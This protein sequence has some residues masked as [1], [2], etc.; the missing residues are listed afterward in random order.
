VSTTDSTAASPVGLLGAAQRNLWRRDGYLHL[1]SALTREHVDRLLRGVDEAVSAFRRLPDDQQTAHMGATGSM[2][3]DDMRLRNVVSLSGFMDEVLDL[4][5]VFEP[6][7]ALLGPY[8]QVCGTEILLRRPNPD[9]ALMLHVDG[10]SGLGR[11]LPNFDSNISHVK[12]LFFLTDVQGV[13]QGNVILVPGSHEVEFPRASS[14]LA[15]HPLRQGS[16]QLQARAGDVIL[17]PATLWHAVAPNKSQASR[18]SLVVWYSQLWARPVDY[19][20][21]ESRVLE[22]LSK[23]QRLLLGA[24]ADA[25]PVTYYLPTQADYLATM[26]AGVARDSSELF[27]YFDDY[28]SHRQDEETGR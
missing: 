17:F 5:A 24:L 18:I 15:S 1:Q 7:L 8:I 2:D 3:S 16:I 19:H 6:A 28:D 9:D 14:A 22:R 11:M 4:P 23:R 10:G 20:H 26:T 27:P 25:R 21:I 12:A 13:D